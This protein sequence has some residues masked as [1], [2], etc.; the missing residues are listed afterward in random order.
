MN[1]EILLILFNSGKLSDSFKIMKGPDW[2]K[3]KT[4][5]SLHFSEFVGKWVQCIGS[6]TDFFRRSTTVSLNYIMID[7]ATVGVGDKILIC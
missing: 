2:S 6:K 5:A 1:L 4:L 7:L 3:M